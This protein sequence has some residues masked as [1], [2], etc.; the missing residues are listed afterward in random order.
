MP[1]TL[2]RALLGLLIPFLALILSSC[3]DPAVESKKSLQNAKHY[4]DEHKLRAAAIELKNALQAD[5]GNA[6]ARYLL[7]MN[8]LYFGDVAGAEKE[9]RR[10]IKAG[11][12]EEDAFIG[13]A[14][15]LINGNAYQN[16]ID[17]IKIKDEYTPKTRANLLA[18]RA[19]AFLGQGKNDLAHSELAK[20]VQLDPNALHVMK[21]TI[22]FDSKNG[23]FSGA[24]RTLSQALAV[25]PESQEL[26]LLET[27]AALQARDSIRAVTA[28]QKVIEL[29]PP[30]ITTIYG[31]HARLRLASIYIKGKQ[32]EKAEAVLAPLFHMFPNDPQTN[33]VG[34]L[35]AFARGNYDKSEERL[36][37]V[38]QLSPHHPQTLLLYGAVSFQKQNY[39]KAATYLS[40]YI[41]TAPHS[42][43][44]RKLLGRTYMILGQNEQARETF[45]PGLEG[46]A[47]DVELLALVGLN[48]IREGE[49]DSGI[50][51]LEKAAQ[52]AP[53]NTALR[54]T[55]AKAYIASGEAELA[56]KELTSILEETDD[57]ENTR[58]LLVLAYLKGGQPDQAI[59]TAL[60]I[61]AD[62][63]NNPAAITLVGSIFAA[64]GDSKEARNYYDQALKHSPGN[65]QAAFA[66]A[67]LEES[68]GNLAEASKMYKA[69]VADT[70]SVIAMLALARLAEKQ[71]NRKELFFWLE[72]ARNE[73]P[74]QI[75]PR[76][77]LVEAYLRDRDIQKAETIVYESREIAP[78]NAIVLGQWARVLMESKRFND[79][80]P[81]LKELIEK[82]PESVFARLLL[83]ETYL[84]LDQLEHTAREL[85]VALEKD[86]GSIGALVLMAKM[87]LKRGR[88]DQAQHYAKQIQ[89]LNPDIFVGYELSGDT[90][91][92]RQQYTKAKLEY[93]KAW[94]IQPSSELVIKTSTAAVRSGSPGEAIDLLMTWSERHPEDVRAWQ[95][96]GT[97]VQSTGNLHE[98]VSI[99]EK[100]LELHPDN[101]VA[102]NNLAGIYAKLGDARALSLAERAY[103]LA[104]EN[105]G[106][107]DTYGWVL[108]QEGDV[109]QGL[110]LLKA[111]HKA[112][113][114]HPEVKYHYAAA[115]IMAG[116]RAEG[117][118]ILRLLLKEDTRF[119][120]RD[121]AEKLLSEYDKD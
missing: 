101:L 81:A 44:A 79:A 104:P 67:Q 96:L 33:Y 41:N 10:S 106:V 89:A 99:Y 39:E 102:V 20:A 40:N 5:P 87:E 52:Y 70:N 27:T 55:L 76:I 91:F 82:E 118:E 117:K 85:N 17:E 36:L 53:Q 2:I 108:T 90:L 61:L 84:N 71:S 74:G 115:L 97:A 25:Y 21:A 68:E 15:A 48:E 42:I 66:L 50:E 69:I 12:N 16:V 54:N 9:F 75:R 28:L 31:R 95:L 14:R 8:N 94:S 92:A 47:G 63:P 119:N 35:L 110:S 80:L 111:A 114:E 93:T 78:D 11:W 57:K 29:D 56:I 22:A 19:A 37:K 109:A 18:M 86:P 24:D 112:M 105:P 51:S 30:K 121:E 13:L 45:T 7:G 77:A 116:E 103:R 26:L 60:E 120:G 107:K 64:T 88:F 4:L 49:L 23:N 100:I 34:G 38:M 73:A 98:A 58:T 1:R 6:E 43:G 3:S 32:L 72:R 62:N 83:A 59:D 46:S 65:P 113:P